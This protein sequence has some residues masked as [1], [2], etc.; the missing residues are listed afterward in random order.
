LRQNIMSNAIL[1]RR[2]NSLLKDSNQVKYIFSQYAKTNNGIYALMDVKSHNTE[3]LIELHN[4]ISEGVHKVEDIE[5]N[6]NSLL[7]A[8][9][10]PEDEKNIQGFQSFLDRVE[11]I[12]SLMSWICRPKWKSIEIFS[13]N[14]STITFCPGR[15][16]ILP[17]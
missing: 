9:M 7:L 5:E 15:S 10:N 17:G 3:R 11:Y 4:I 16:I 13:A 8:V 2:I 1:Q 12:I 6:V 14:T